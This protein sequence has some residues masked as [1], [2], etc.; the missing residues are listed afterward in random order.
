MDDS[1]LHTLA[2]LG[3]S[4]WIDFLSRNL[5]KQGEL[6]R[7]MRDDAIVGVTSN[8]TI[9][10]KAI[11]EGNAYDDQLRELVAGES[12]PRELFYQLAVTDVRDACDLL[13]DAWENGR[14]RARRERLARGRSRPRVRHPGDDRPG[15]AAR[16]AGGPPEPR[17]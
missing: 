8:P 9:F 2:G 12:D 14:A 3:Q 4:P 11:S 13:R 1:R 17:T 5:L 6:E 10:Q 15:A 16:R 7:M